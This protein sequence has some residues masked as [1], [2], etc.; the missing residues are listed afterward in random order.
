MAFCIYC[1][2]KLEDDHHFCGSCGARVNAAPAVSA[3]VVEEPAYT[4]SVA[5]EPVY[6]V[7]VMEESVW[8]APVHTEPVA[9]DPVEPAVPVEPEAAPH[10]EPVPAADPAPIA[11]LSAAPITREHVRNSATPSGAQPMPFGNMSARGSSA[12]YSYATQERVS[13]PVQNKTVRPPRKFLSVFFS[14]VLCILILAMMLPTFMLITASNALKQETFLAV[15]NRIDLDEIPASVID[16]YDEDL[17]DMSFAEALCEAIND[18]MDY[19]NGEYYLNDDLVIYEWENLTPKTL[20]R[21]LKGT[22]FLPFIAE[23][24]E[25]IVEAILEG[26]GSYTISEK[27]LEKLFEENIAY[28]VEQM[29][30][31]LDEENYHLLVEEMVEEIGEG[32]I[33]LPAFSRSDREVL[34]IVNIALSFTGIG[35]MCLVLILLV[36]LLFVANHRDPMYAVRDTGIV[37]VVGTIL[38]LLLMLGGRAAV[39]VFA[40]KD[41]V[42]YLVCTVLSCIA[43]SSLLVVGITFGLG[44]VLLVVNGIV[45]KA[46]RKRCA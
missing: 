45:R 39:S 32:E 29:G 14:V 7:P 21:F 9:E 41:A 33:E 24:A 17:E 8:E 28:I 22:S 30:I 6:T 36:L 31:P 25:G 13:N 40:G 15:L 37:C 46:Q 44:I 20:D 5:E 10:E 26:K 18:E 1:G 23:Q 2:A 19:Y 4:A 43:E 3:P 38:P 34:G 11:P 27:S 12:S 16:E 42:M 35:A